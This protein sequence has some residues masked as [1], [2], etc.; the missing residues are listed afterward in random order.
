MKKIFICTIIGT[1]LLF[2]S[3]KVEKPVEPVKTITV[4]GQGSV[5]LK[6]DL[7]SIRFSVKNTEWIVNTAIDKN[8]SNT[9]KAI[10]KIKEAGVDETDISTFDYKITQDANGKYIVTNTI[11]VLI[12]NSELIGNVIN[13]AIINGAISLID[14]KYLISDKTTALR[15]AR[16][17]AIQDA[18]DTASLYAG[19]S[20]CL[21][22][23]VMDIK[24]N[25]NYTTFRPFFK[26]N[27][28]TF[29]NPFQL[30]EGE[31]TITAGVT[32][33]YALVN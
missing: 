32:I 22:D 4:S 7:L 30:E 33:T 26:N 5:N 8:A 25:G 6:P 18:K 24:E 15:Q 31:I 9:E 2:S 13:G 23:S 3:C 11:A 29:S 21:L 1:A 10:S 28:Q 14:Y 17:L 12:R 20:G 19:A 16:T 27:D